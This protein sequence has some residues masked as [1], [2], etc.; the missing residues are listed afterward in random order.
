M[1]VYIAGKITG[2][3][4]YKAQFANA[5]RQI[6]E[7][8]HIVLNPAMLPGGMSQAD[9]MRIC[10]AMID[11]AD[12]VWLLPSARASKGA[13]LETDYS[14]YCRKTVRRLSDMLWFYADAWRGVEDG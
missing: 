11:T 10:F 7:Q 5:A 9:Y 8:G 4:S 3:A 1:K 13:E 14:N 12:E 2:N 6:E